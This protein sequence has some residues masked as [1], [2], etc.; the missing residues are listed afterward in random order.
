MKITCAI[1]GHVGDAERFLPANVGILPEDVLGPGPD[2]VCPSC[3]SGLYVPHPFT[4]D[5]L[6]A[7]GVKDAEA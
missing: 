3:L 4:L 2:L 6:A 7:L 1:C 5:D